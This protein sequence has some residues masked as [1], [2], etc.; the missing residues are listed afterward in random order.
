[1]AVSA[2]RLPATCFLRRD[3]ASG[4][5]YS[6][7][8]A[9][10]ARVPAFPGSGLEDRQTRESLSPAFGVQLKVIF[11]LNGTA[12]ALNGR[13]CFESRALL[14]RL[15]RGLLRGLGRTYLALSAGLL[16]AQTSVEKPVDRPLPDIHQLMLE[17]EAHQKQLDKVRENY[18][19]TS[20][21]TTQN[22][23]SSGQVK[24]TETTE[25]EDFFVNSHVIERTVKKD[26]NALNAHEE[27][28]ETERVTKLVEKAEKTPRDQPLDGPSI[29]ITRVLE[30][31]DVRN[32]RR[33]MFRGRR[34]IVFDF[35]GRKDAKT[36]GLAEDASKKLKGTLWVDE[37]DREVAHLEVSFDDNFHVAGGLVANVEKGSSFRFDQEPVNGEIWLPTGGEGTI[38]L[39]LL[40]VKG[41]REHF[42]ER[43]YDFK[44]F[45][46]DTH[47]NTDARSSGD[48]K[49]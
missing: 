36:H 13:T 21:Q 29:S 49:P 22:L 47:E 24:K 33:E 37:A 8:Q 45:R 7:I 12:S 2:R 18:T 31:M 38:Q 28:K 15:L 44:R 11:Q 16:V 34:T 43:D 23:D 41:V 48:K 30:I 19:Y 42:T 39:R 3:A 25:N 1:M 26:G 20:E 14:R 32:P 10:Q 6:T 46:V 5:R 35:V 27:Q 40:L 17:V 9:A 4:F